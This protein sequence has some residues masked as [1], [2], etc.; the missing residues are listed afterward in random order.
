[1]SYGVMT[2]ICSLGLVL[3]RRTR[4]PALLQASSIV[5]N[6]AV[7][8]TVLA[9]AAIFD[10]VERYVVPGLMI[11]VAFAVAIMRLLLVSAVVATSTYITAY[12]VL[13]AKRGVL[14]AA[15]VVSLGVLLGGPTE[16]NL[17]ASRPRSAGRD[18]GKSV[19][20]S[21]ALPTKPAI[22]RPRQGR[23]RARVKACAAPVRQHSEDAC[24]ARG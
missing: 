3:T 14:T 23:E 16:E 10:N 18:L 8:F 21:R 6:I 12:I 15:D 17:E 9:G 22:D 1:M 5:S 2:S 24:R 7:G 11:S 20:R 4:A 19:T 13:M